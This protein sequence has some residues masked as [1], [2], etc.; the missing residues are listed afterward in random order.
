MNNR[1]TSKYCEVDK[2]QRAHLTD[3]TAMSFHPHYLFIVLFYLVREERIKDLT[4]QFGGGGLRW[5]LTV[6][7]YLSWVTN[8]LS[9]GSSPVNERMVKSTISVCH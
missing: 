3:A 6:L 2:T 7:F 5:T 1:C 9:S 8:G 4:H